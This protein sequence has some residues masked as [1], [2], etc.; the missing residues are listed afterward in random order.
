MRISC[1]SGRNPGGIFSIRTRIQR[2]LHSEERGN[3]I[4]EMAIALPVMMFL[5]TGIFSFSN[6]LYQ[7]L[8]LAEAVSYGGHVL[9]MDRGDANPCATATAAIKAA[10]PHLNPANLTLTYTFNGI[11]QGTG[12]TSCTGGAADLLS[13]KNAMIQASYSCGLGVYG[14]SFGL[15]TIYEQITEVVQ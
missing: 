1:V 14:H 6:A 4:V 3:A 15:C 11:S 10:A 2:L 13:K 7:K 9:A 5:M 8:S 12:T